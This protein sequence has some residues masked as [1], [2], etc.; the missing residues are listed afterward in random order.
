MEKK[1]HHVQMHVKE[2]INSGLTLEC[3]LPLYLVALPTKYAG[4]SAKTSN[5]KT[6]GHLQLSPPNKEVN[7]RQGIVLYI[8][9]ISLS[10]ML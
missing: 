2:G 1:H 8:R 4:H 5:L 10:Y 6:I 9:T 7:L 3:Y